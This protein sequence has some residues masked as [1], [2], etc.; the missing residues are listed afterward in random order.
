MKKQIHY[1]KSIVEVVIKRFFISAFFTSL[2]LIFFAATNTT[3]ALDEHLELSSSANGNNPLGIVIEPSNGEKG[4][5]KP[6]NMN[7]MTTSGYPDLGDDQVFP[8]AAGLDSY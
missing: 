2:I 1:Y 5:S 6:N 3:M 8:F 4:K 7:K